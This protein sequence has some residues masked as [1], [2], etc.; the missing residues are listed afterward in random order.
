QVKYARE[1]A[2]R[3]KVDSLVEFIEDDYRNSVKYVAPNSIDKV[4]SVGMM[5][6]VR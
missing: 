4:V 6:H 1:W 3:E 2:K 5:D